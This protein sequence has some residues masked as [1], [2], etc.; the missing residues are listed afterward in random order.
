M[1]LGINGYNDTF[2]AF[3]D[4]ACNHPGGAKGARMVTLCNLSSCGV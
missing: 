1:P 2:K 3:T 4:F